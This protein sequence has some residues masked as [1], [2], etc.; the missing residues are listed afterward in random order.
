M[1][2]RFTLQLWTKSES[3]VMMICHQT[4]DSLIRI[5]LQ[6]RFTATT[7]SFP[8]MKL[9]VFSENSIFTD[10]VNKQI[11]EIVTKH[12]NFSLFLVISTPN[13]SVCEARKG[14]SQ[15]NGVVIRDVSLL[16]DLSRR[17]MRVNDQVDENWEYNEQWITSLSPLSQVWCRHKWRVNSTMQ[18]CDFF[19][20]IMSHPRDEKKDDDAGVT[21]H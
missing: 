20:I 19:L 5:R 12:E 21:I 10:Q 1:Y 13:N 7:N 3:I 18:Y 16:S 4:S 2:F 15:Y 8:I 9:V 14:Y 11:N 6:D 17:V